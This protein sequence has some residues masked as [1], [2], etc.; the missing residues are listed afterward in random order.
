MIA[1]STNPLDQTFVHPEDYGMVTELLS[2]LQK[3]RSKVGSK[4][5][6]A[7]DALGIKLLNDSEFVLRNL[8]EKLKA[9]SGKIETMLGYINRSAQEEV[10]GGQLETVKRCPRPNWN[11][12]HVVVGTS[13]QR[14][15]HGKINSSSSSGV[16]N[17]TSCLQSKWEDLRPGM[18]M[19]ASVRNVVPFGCFCDLGVQHDGLL[20]ST[21]MQQV[22]LKV[23]DAITV[24]VLKIDVEGSSKQ[25]HN[26]T[27]GKKARKNKSVAPS[28]A[29]REKAKPRIALSFISFAT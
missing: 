11:V 23:G 22:V 12:Q 28:T 5:R 17:A 3:K 1:D 7:N 16:A 25:K 29:R 19:R 24:E 10:R 4:S 6:V 27:T 18:M 20:H 21:R 15:R 14:K 13:G 2:H 9:K 26:G 8:P